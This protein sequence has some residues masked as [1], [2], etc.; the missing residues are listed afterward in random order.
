MNY[1]NKKDYISRIADAIEKIQEDG[2]IPSGETTPSIEVEPLYVSSNGEYTA[3]EGHAYNP[4]EVSI[5]DP[6]FYKTKIVNNSSIEIGV[7]KP[8]IGTVSYRKM[9]RTSYSY[10]P[11]NSTL[12]V[13][14]TAISGTYVITC[15]YTKELAFSF[16]TSGLYSADIGIRNRIRYYL[17]FVPSNS[18]TYTITVTDAA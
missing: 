3:D 7:L 11:S 8:E 16:S 13:N 2:G 15:T 17:V 5:S 18:S 1:L 14:C 4:V 12:D 6:S 10:I 9:V